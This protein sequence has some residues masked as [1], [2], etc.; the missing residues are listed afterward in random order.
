MTESGRGP[1]FVIEQN[2]ATGE[3][4]LWKRELNHSAADRDGIS[5]ADYIHAIYS[6]LRQLRCREVLM[7]GCGGGTLATMLRR[8]G[9]TAILVDNDKSSFDIAQRYFHLPPDIPCHVADGQAFLRGDHRRYDAIVLDAYGDSAI[10]RH[11]LKSAF[12]DLVKS[13]LKP[14][15]AMLLVNVVVADDDDPTADRIAL[16]LRRTWHHVRLLDSVASEDRNAIVLA[17]SVRTLKRPR[18]LMRPRTGTRKLA[19]E[20]KALDFRPLRSSP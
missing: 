10:P 16:R 4:A 9:V 17:G 12:F 11:L 7:I 2:N 3:V 5:L 8:A 13:R 19:A 18:L 14:R 15:N 1:G 20:L 6:F